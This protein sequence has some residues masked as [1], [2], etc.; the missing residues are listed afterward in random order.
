MLF[1]F[2]FSSPEQNKSFITKIPLKIFVSTNRGRKTNLT[3]MQTT[4]NI[5]NKFALNT[6]NLIYEKVT[7]A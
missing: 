5:I 4:N 3:K 6:I 2:F 7:E 1:S